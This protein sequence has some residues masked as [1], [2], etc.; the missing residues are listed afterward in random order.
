MPKRALQVAGSDE[1]S[2]DDVTGYVNMGKKGTFDAKAHGDREKIKALGSFLETCGGSGSL[3]QSWTCVVKTKSTSGDQ[4]TI[5]HDDKNGRFRSKCEV[6]RHF[7]LQQPKT[8]KT[9]DGSSNS[10]SLV[11]SKAT[12]LSEADAVMMTVVWATIKGYPPW[13]AEI[14]HAVP[15]PKFTV[16]FFATDNEATL[17][18]R[19][20]QR[21]HKKQHKLRAGQGK[22]A[23]AVLQAQF[24]EAVKLADEA[25][26]QGTNTDGDWRLEGS[27]Y[28]GLRIRRVFP[29]GTSDALVQSWLPAGETPEEFAL[30]H[31][32]YDDGDEE[33]LEEHELIDGI[34]SLNST[35]STG[36]FSAGENAPAMI[37]DATPTPSAR[38]LERRSLEGMEG[39]RAVLVE[40][41]LVGYVDAL[42]ADGW[43][44]LMHLAEVD[45]AQRKEIGISVGM[46]S[47]HA[48]K[49]ASLFGR[50][51]ERVK[52]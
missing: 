25:L 38:A 14:V 48:A 41:G 13:P 18:E 9:S 40:M 32:V 43:D 29:G 49:F 36:S 19:A 10:T 7:G 35:P 47:G 20:L 17:P 46:K 52:A 44:D 33:D 34:T 23:S 8:A 6:A 16:R 45:E 26:G 1:E 30:W 21:Y 39:V 28:I 24:F 27:T 12:P 15:G 11:T 31:V 22:V 42:E 3:V 51:L 2:D 5:Y 4:W 37:A 50:V